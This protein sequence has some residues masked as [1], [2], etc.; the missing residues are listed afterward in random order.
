MN[1]NAFS[2]FL[3]DRIGNLQTPEDIQKFYDVLNKTEGIVWTSSFASGVNN[4]T[5]ESLRAIEIG[6]KAPH[7]NIQFAFEDTAHFRAFKEFWNEYGIKK[8]SSTGF[9]FISSALAMC[10]HVKV[11]GFWPF[12]K[13]V[14]GRQLSYHYHD[15]IKLKRGHDMPFEFKFVVAM[16]HFG[17][18]KI[19]AGKCD[20]GDFL[21]TP[22]ATR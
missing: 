19:H 14:D 2:S 7:K 15:D 12:T 9:Y 11:F 5:K 6:R 18:L 1:Y 8:W 4:Y 17:L 21:G 16:H 22:G 20:A 13:Y 10:D 3:I